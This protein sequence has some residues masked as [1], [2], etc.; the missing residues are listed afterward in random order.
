MSIE[1]RDL[2]KLGFDG[3]YEDDI[4]YLDESHTAVIHPKYGLVG[5][6][7]MLE[8]LIVMNYLKHEHTPFEDWMGELPDAEYYAIK[9]LDEFDRWVRKVEFLKNYLLE[10]RD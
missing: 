10:L 9:N 6:T 3:S 5:S 4:A 1:F 8:K 2:K 7:Q